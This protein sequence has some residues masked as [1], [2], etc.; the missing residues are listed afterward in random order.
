MIVLDYGAMI[1]KKEATRELAAIK[2]A[3]KQARV[4]TRARRKIY[5]F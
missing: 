3:E 5:G 2:E 1:D 4:E